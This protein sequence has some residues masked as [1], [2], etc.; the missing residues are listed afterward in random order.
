VTVLAKEQPLAGA[1]VELRSTLVWRADSD[2]QGVARLYGVGAGFR[3]LR[4]EAPGFAQLA[5]MVVTDAGPAVQRLVVRLEAGHVASGRVL[6]PDGRPVAGAR[7]WRRSASDPFPVVDPA[8]DAV[9]SDG[10]GRWR[11]AALV[12]GSYQFLASHPDFA[13]T[14]SAPIS[15]NRPADGIDLRLESGGRIAGVVRF[16]DG[17]PVAGAEV[18]AAALSGMAISPALSEVF[19]DD[20]GRFRL[21]GMPR[22]TVHLNALHESG[23]SPMVTA[24]LVAERQAAV[25]LTLSV[26]GEIAGLVVDSRGQPLPEAQVTARHDAL[27]KRGPIKSGQLTTWDLRGIPTLISDAG[28]RFRFSG[29]PEGGYTLQ[30]LR[31]GAPPDQRALA[32]GVTAQPGDRSVRLVVRADGRVTGR[33]VLED[34]TPAPQFAVSFGDRVGG[35]V[36]TPFSGTDGAFSLS[37]PPGQHDLLITG[38]SFATRELENVLL[39]EDGRKDLGTITVKRGRSISG[40]VL[41]PDGTPVPEAQVVAA[42]WMSGGGDRLFIRDESGPAQETTSDADGRFTLSGFEPGQ[43]LVV[44]ERTGLGRSST[45]SVP[46]QPLSAQVDLVLRQTGSLEGKVTRDG[47]PFADT[48]VIA[49]ARESTANF[50]VMTGPD[51]RYALDTLAPGPQMVLAFVNRRKDMLTR[52]VTVEAGRRARADLD[53]RT[54]SITLTVNV[55]GSDGKPAP[56]QVMVVTPPFPIAENETVAQ[57]RERFAP[58]EPTSVY[59]R[60]GQ[61]KV[62]V[63]GLPAGRYQICAARKDGPLTCKQQE[64]T[65]STTVDLVVPPAVATSP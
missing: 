28:G 26:R 10:A 15:V 52:A 13:Q 21:D 65:A 5:Q 37:G 32:A 54:G 60:G 61:G 39:D 33:V 57:A 22:R 58:V 62:E 4:V 50:F 48:V 16:E 47:Q 20:D 17:R 40:R 12:P 6:D 25:V 29:L 27:W 55:Q 3:A 43:L 49:T 2:A 56:G 63:E 11:I 38:P 30:A 64:V 8:F 34:G 46:P 36:P 9:T 53:V 14:V 59:L 7:V 35:V 51:G 18:R 19:T 41:A 45:I 42:A 24:D 1:H 44:A 31:P 23:A